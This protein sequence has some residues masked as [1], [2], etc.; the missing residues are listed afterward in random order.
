MG[1]EGLAELNFQIQTDKNWIKN[2]S[3]YTQYE[4]DG[5]ITCIAANLANYESL[6][7]PSYALVGHLLP[8]G[9]VIMSE[10]Y[11]KLATSSNHTKYNR[12]Q[13]GI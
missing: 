13:N 5:K 8:T 7:H 12:C 11:G 4:F 1:P 10:M 9:I 3:F 6:S 2:S